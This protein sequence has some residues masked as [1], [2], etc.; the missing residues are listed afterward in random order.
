MTETEPESMSGHPETLDLQP[1]DH[2]ADENPKP[3]ERQG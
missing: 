2:E 1:V 3:D